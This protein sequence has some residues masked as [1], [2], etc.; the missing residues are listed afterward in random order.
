MGR[1][2]HVGREHVEALEVEAEALA[3][4][5][6]TAL[7]YYEECKRVEHKGLNETCEAVA[8]DLGL[9]VAPDAGSDSGPWWQRVTDS[10]PG[11]N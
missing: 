9:I 3:G 11:T 2:D 10:I 1:R 5:V 7:D 6:T 8:I 4:E